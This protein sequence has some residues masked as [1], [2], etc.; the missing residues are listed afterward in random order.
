MVDLFEMNIREKIS[1]NLIYFFC[2]YE[3]Y[4]YQFPKVYL[5]TNWSLIWALFTYCKWC[6]PFQGG[7]VFNLG[8]NYSTLFIVHTITGDTIVVGMETQTV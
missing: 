4:V 3:P 5:D 1:L 7:G 2:I 8:R 6:N